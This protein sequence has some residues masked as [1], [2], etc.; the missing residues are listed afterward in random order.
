VT[1]IRATALAVET[2]DAGSGIAATTLVAEIIAQD[3]AAELRATL[4][5]AEALAYE[6]VPI[7]L[8]ALVAE[9]LAYEPITAGCATTITTCW[10]IVRRDGVTKRFT[11]LDRDLVVDGFTYRS[12]RSIDASAIEASASTAPANLEVLGIIDA[13]EITTDDLVAGLYDHALVE[14]FRVDWADPARGIQ[15]LHRGRIG[16]VKAGAAMYQAELLSPFEALRQ[17]IVD[18][19]TPECRWDLGEAFGVAGQ[20]GCKIDLA[21]WTVSGTVSDAT[22]RR[23]FGAGALTQGDGHFDYGL[24]TF[25]SGLNAGHAREVKSWASRRFELWDELPFDL[26]VGDSFSVHAGCDK[27]RQTCRDKFANI[28]N[29]G[30]F[31]DIPGLDRLLRYPDAKA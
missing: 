21:A 24:L 26:A 23:L 1:D 12:C 6:P 27:R 22:S 31:P 15:M 17:R 13:A 11:T 28:L 14:L 10:V 8:T 4:L 9:A 20:A 19:Y 5:V 16:V 2:I 18:A 29:F 7:A 30:G 25:T 3:V